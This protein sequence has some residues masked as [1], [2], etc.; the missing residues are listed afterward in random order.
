MGIIKTYKILI[1]EGSKEQ[2]VIQIK[3]DNIALSM[4]QYQRNRPHFTWEIIDVG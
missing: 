1:T 4:E 3:T 2:H